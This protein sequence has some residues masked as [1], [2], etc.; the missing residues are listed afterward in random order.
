MYEIHSTRGGLPRAIKRNDASS[1]L[2]QATQCAI[3]GHD[4]IVIKGDDGRSFTLEEFGIEAGGAGKQR[5]PAKLVSA[6]DQ[7]NATHDRS[8]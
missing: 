8:A 4:H 3:D 2:G 5:D 1:A 6:L 7:K